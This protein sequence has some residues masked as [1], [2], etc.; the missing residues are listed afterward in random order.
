[1]ANL[2]MTDLTLIICLFLFCN[3][4]LIDNTAP[5]DRND[6]D[7]FKLTYSCSGLGSGMGSMQ[8][9]FKVSGTDYMYTYQQNSFYGVPD[10]QPDTICIGTL[11]SSSIDSIVDLVKDIQDTIVYRTNLGIMSGAI[12]HLWVT[13]D[14]IEVTFKLHNANDTTAQKIVD[15]LNSNIPANKKRL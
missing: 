11:R 5:T 12:Q 15:I 1:V 3:S 2:K 9:T 14:N 10:K 4:G 8:P 6:Y 7:N 13:H